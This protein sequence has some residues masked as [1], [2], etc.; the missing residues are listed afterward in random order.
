MEVSCSLCGFHF[1]NLNQDSSN[2]RIEHVKRQHIAKRHK[3]IVKATW[4]QCSACKKY[5]PT[6][7]GLGRHK[8]KYTKTQNL[9]R[10]NKK[11]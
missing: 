7:R 6:Q 1:E 2:N 4:F 10:S 5:L 8:C 9:K 3:D 11:V